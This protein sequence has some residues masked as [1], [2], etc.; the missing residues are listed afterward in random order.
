MIV[1]KFYCVFCTHFIFLSCKVYCS[2][3]LVCSRLEGSQKNFKFILH[4]IWNCWSVVKHSIQCACMVHLNGDEKMG[5]YLGCG[6]NEITKLKH[7]TLLV[8]SHVYIL[9]SVLGLPILMCIYSEA[10]TIIC[11]TPHRHTHLHSENASGV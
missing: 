8:L 6:A 11:T 2:V 3:Q 1:E 5:W 9:K 10:R 4:C 7:V